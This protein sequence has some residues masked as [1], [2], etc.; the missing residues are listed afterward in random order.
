MIKLHIA[1][2]ELL[3]VGAALYLM[4]VFMMRGQLLRRR[5]RGEMLRIKR[6]DAGALPT[7]A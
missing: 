5:L 2:W 3:G 1:L 6:D 7:A 4:A